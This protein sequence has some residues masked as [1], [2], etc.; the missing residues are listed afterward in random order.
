MTKNFPTFGLIRS[1]LNETWG[2]SRYVPP[3]FGKVYDHV[4]GY[5]LLLTLQ[6][7]LRHAEKLTIGFVNSKANLFSL[8]VGFIYA[9]PFDLKMDTPLATIAAMVVNKGLYKAWSASDKETRSA[10]P[11]RCN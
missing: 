5:Q 9:R 8:R 6:E 10:E 4:S 3:Q 1:S 2:H 7:Q 11:P